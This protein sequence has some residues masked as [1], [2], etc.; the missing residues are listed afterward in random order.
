LVAG[1]GTALSPCVLP[2]LP[3]LLAGGATGRKPVRIV[4]GLVL[5]FSL[6]TLF[7]TWLLSELGLPQDLLRNVAIGF[8]F[9]M[10]AVLL[11]PPLAQLIERA[12]AIFSRLRPAG[13]GGGGFLLGVVLGLVFV[14]CA[15]PFLAAV[16]TAAARHQFGFRA[17]V[18]AFSYGIGAGIPMLAIA[19][20]G[21]EI[22]VHIRR[23]AVLVRNVAGVL[24]VAVAFGLVFHL[25]DHLTQISLPWTSY[26][27]NH[28]EK[29]TD[30]QKQ[31]RKVSGER[32]ALAPKK[33]VAGSNLPNYGAAPPILADGAWIDSKPLTLT[34]LHGKV[35]LVDF[36]TYSCINCLR[37]LPHL[38]SWYAAYHA[39]GLDI[40]GVH[41]PEFAFEHVTSNVEAAVKRLGIPYPVVQDNKYRT[42]DGYANEYWPAEYLIDRNGDVRYTSFGESDY[43]ATQNAIRDLLG[44]TGVKAK[45]VP[46][47]TPTEFQTPESYLGYARLERYAG[48]KPVPNR[49][50]SYTFAKK[51]PLNDLSYAGRWTVAGEYITAGQSAA[52]RL[53][54]QADDIYIV[55]GGKG[56]VQTLIDG[57]PTGTLDVNS[58]RLYTVL[59]G[60]TSRNGVL[61]LRFSPGVRAYSFTFG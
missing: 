34:Q 26:I 60:K 30:A 9:L 41:T 40:V 19:F 13:S 55:L 31:E 48:S 14:P 44:D 15:G 32:A 11:L 47:L 22:A 45:T 43:D 42:W 59:A 52:L 16:S 46:N 37:T 18:A 8:L 3:I 24:V 61:E 58:Y 6:F 20:G 21:R 53:H 57:K 12:L 33:N 56:T 5:S 23:N 27:Q 35:V 36:W 25:D 10:A 50:A 4:G 28:V 1:V 51:L 17:V 29:S 49:E 7:A 39:K 2:V 54:F 38:K